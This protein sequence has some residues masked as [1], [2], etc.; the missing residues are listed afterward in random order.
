MNSRSLRG[1]A[2]ILALASLGACAGAGPGADGRLVCADPR[3]QACTMDY[4][5]VCATLAD[6]STATYANGC[7][8]CADAAVVAHRPGACE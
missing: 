1:P 7:G 3:P 2:A 5:P 8:A 4:R 6:G